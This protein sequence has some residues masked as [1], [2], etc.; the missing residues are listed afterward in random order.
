[1]GSKG[2]GGGKLFLPSAIATD[3]SG[4]LWIADTSNNRIAEFNSKGEFV[5]VAGRDV[6]KTKVDAAGTEAER[7]ICTAASGNTCQAGTTGST[8]GQLNAPKGIATTS[9]GAVWIADT[10]NNKLKKFSS[11][12]VFLTSVSSEGSEAGQVKEPV[13]IAVGPEN[14]LWVADAG[15]NRVEQW[16]AKGFFVKQFGSAGSGNGQFSRPAAIDVDSSGGIWVGDQTNNRVQQF[17]STGEYVAQYGTSAEF[18]FAGPMG[19]DADDKGGV[20]VTDTNHNRIQ[21]LSA[22]QF[23]KPA[24]TQVPAID[25]SYGSGLLT[26]MEL[27]EPEAPDPAITVASSSGLTSSVSSGSDTATYSYASG[28]LTAAK[29]PEG[30]TKYERD[31]SNRITKITLPNGT[32]AKVTYDEFGRALTVTVKPTGGTEKTTSFWYSETSRESKVWGGGEPEIIYS[33]GEDGS[34]VK[35]WYAKVSPTL[36]GF[37]GSLWSNRNSPTPIENKNHYFAVTAK[38]QN[39]IAS[40]QLLV[41]GNA[42][43]EEKTCEDKSQPPAH[44]CDAVT[45]DWVTHAAAHPPGQLNLEVVATDF[46]GQEIAERFFVTIPQQPPVDPEAPEPPTYES[47]KQFREDYGLDRNKSTSKS[48]QTRFILELLYEWESQQPTAVT[49]VANW[50]IPMRAPELAEMETR[51]QIAQQASEVIP[52]WAEEHAAASYGGFYVDD[53]A[54]GKI[55][56]GFTENQAVLVSALKQEAGLLS[57]AMVFEFPTPPTS[58]IVNLE[59]FASSVTQ[60]LR[61]SPVT[62]TA[63]S[64]EVAP[65]GNS[66]EVGATD[67]ASVGTFLAGRFGSS[68]P[69]TVHEEERDSLMLSRFPNSGPVIGGAALAIGPS[70]CTAGFGSRAKTGEVRGTPVYTYFTLTA[71]H[72]WP[73]GA[74]V[75]R[76]SERLGETRENAPVGEVKRGPFSVSEFRVTDAEA[77]RIDSGIRSFSVLNPP[78]GSRVLEAQSIQG[79]EA[80]KVGRFVCWSGVMSGPHCGRVTVRYEAEQEDG[81]ERVLYKVDGPSISG[82]SGGPVWDPYTHKAVGL[83][84]TGVR[85]PQKKCHVVYGSLNSCPRMGFT[86]LIP[87]KLSGEMPGVTAFLGVQVLKEE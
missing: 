62:G 29:D 1:M 83:I 78:P 39:E 44:N 77:I 32:W 45:L 65:S 15:N 27:E 60:A 63:V 74:T 50:G 71:G 46:L 4:N 87:G 72:C 58:P 70:F 40:V 38:S 86:P 10:G 28:N 12:G 25:Y 26:K 81:H 82:D 21:K 3:P 49:A 16:S 73:H 23:A 61:G 33:F 56:V 24:V 47:I 36:E 75:Y 80:P 6:N 34:L 5:L 51:K 7:S 14:G 18:S 67:P 53:R 13:A 55:Y 22:S 41:N 48:E 64:V 59:V 37:E 85:S 66:V 79:V 52:Q 20:W 54:G 9:E 57:P 19:V 69:I 35:W 11:G 30:E 31:T 43:V 84:T 68:A 8:G 42:V 2:S 17:S 76:Q